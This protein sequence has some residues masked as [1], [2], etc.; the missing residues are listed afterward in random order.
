MRTALIGRTTLRF[1]AVAG[2]GP[3]PREG[4]VV[5]S[6][7]SGRRKLL[8]EWD[9]GIVLETSMRFSGEWHLY[10]TDVRWQKSM[11]EA[12]AIIEVQGWVAVCF[13]A[14]DIETYRAPDQHRHPQCGGVGPDIRS[15]RLD[16]VALVDRMIEYSD[17][18]A[19][20]AEVLGDP[21]VVTGIGNVDRSEILWTV[22][23]DPRTEF[24]E[25]TEDDCETLVDVARQLVTMSPEKMSVYGRVGQMCARC[26]GTIVGRR[27]GD[28]P[29][30]V[31]WCPE[32]Q[33]DPGE[34]LVLPVHL[35]RVE[36]HPA[37]L[38]YLNDVR[39]ARQRVQI[40]DDLRRL[41]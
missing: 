4:A 19:S 17:P 21:R 41:G 12:R 6:V 15:P 11:S 9:D 20:V 18:N 16:S 37:E 13:G 25:L 33:T 8:I 23:L 35:Q 29:R 14:V 22:E 10:R 1:D 38:L 40:F 39:A 31:Y 32:C 24:G 30:P 3:H 26:H 5:E 34:G 28:D 7:R 36:A 2:I 27:I